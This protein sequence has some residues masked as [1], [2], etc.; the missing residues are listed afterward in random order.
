MTRVRA[1]GERGLGSDA[2]WDLGAT[3]PTLR[4]VADMSSADSMVSG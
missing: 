2:A 4:V 1:L 3:H